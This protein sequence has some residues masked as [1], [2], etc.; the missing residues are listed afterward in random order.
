MS[1]RK[2]TP[3]LL[4]AIL[5]DTTPL[6]EADAIAPP[7]APASKPKPAAKKPATQVP[8]KRAQAAPPSAP[9]PAPAPVKWEYMEVVFREFR[10]WRPRLVNGRERGDWKIAPV[11][12]DYLAA[13]GAE[14]WELVNITD[15]H[16]NE[17]TA[18]FKRSL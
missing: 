4:G 6:P 9:Q 1:N 7:P 16:H 11:I 10:G 12:N 17:K 5:G 18:Y 14:G 13:L 8:A 3:D 2:E 15:E